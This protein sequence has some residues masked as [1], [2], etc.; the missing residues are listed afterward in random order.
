MKLILL[1]LL[2][3]IVTLSALDLTEIKLRFCNK[4]KNHWAYDRLQ[5][6][7]NCLEM[8]KEIGSQLCVD[9]IKIVLL[10][11]LNLFTNIYIYLAYMYLVFICI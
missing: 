1:V 4:L 5:L 7:K 9:V 11:A 3:G 2:L 10:F 6:K 8:A